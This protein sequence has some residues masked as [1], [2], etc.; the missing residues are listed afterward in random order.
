MFGTRIFFS[1][2]WF[3]LEN[4]LILSNSYTIP[5]KSLGSKHT[6]LL[7]ATGVYIWMHVCIY[8]FHRSFYACLLSPNS[9]ISLLGSCWVMLLF[10]LCYLQKFCCRVWY[11]YTEFITFA[12]LHPYTRSFGSQRCRRSQQIIPWPMDKECRNRK[13]HGVK[14]RGVCFQFL[15]LQCCIPHFIWMFDW[16]HSILFWLLPQMVRLF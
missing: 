8:Q 5:M 11:V 9:C 12:L 16:F 14:H 1:C 13:Y 15:F 3:F 7:V 6:L 10:F 4:W 2:S